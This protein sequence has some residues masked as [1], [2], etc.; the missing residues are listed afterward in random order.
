MRRQACAVH[1]ATGVHRLHLA[2][3][4]LATGAGASRWERG[5]EEKGGRELRGC[6]RGRVV[7]EGERR[8]TRG[9]ETS[10]AMHRPPRAIREGG[11][12]MA[13]VRPLWPR[14][15]VAALEGQCC[16]KMSEPDSY[17]PFDKLALISDS[18]RDWLNY[19]AERERERVEYSGLVIDSNSSITPPL[20]STSTWESMVSG[21]YQVMS[22]RDASIA[23]A[24]VWF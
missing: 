9:A 18:E 16:P 13:L 7:V 4:A 17:R 15:A 5:A 11:C 12:A 1:A 22:A 3:C 24:L 20:E 2:R 10:C 19:D 6:R 23:C 8:S 21:F 14:T